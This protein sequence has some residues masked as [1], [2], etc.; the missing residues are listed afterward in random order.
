MNKPCVA[1]YD[2]SQL[3]TTLGNTPDSRVRLL[4]ELATLAQ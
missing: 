1:V 3:N 2:P 4:P